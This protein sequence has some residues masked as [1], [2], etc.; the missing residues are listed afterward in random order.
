MSAIKFINKYRRII[1]KNLFVKTLNNPIKNGFISDTKQIKKILIVRPNHRLGNQL[2][3]TPLLQEVIKQFPESKIDLFL[4]GNAGQIIFKNYSEVNKIIALPKKHFKEIFKYLGC[5]LYLKRQKYDL[6]INPMTNSSSGTIA[7]NITNS[8]FKFSGIIGNSET[9]VKQD[10]Y[11]HIAKKPVYNFWEELKTVGIN[12]EKY[13]IPKIDI[14]LN[15]KELTEGKEKLSEIVNTTKEIICIFTFA[16]NE[17]CYSK[18][19]WTEFYGK[20]KTEFKNYTIIEILPVE[21]V[22]QIDFIAPSFYS[23]DIR[24]IASVIANTKLFIGADSGMMHL[25]C[26]TDTTTVGLFSVTNLNTYQPYSN[27]N[28]GISTKNTS[29]D[30]IIEKIKAAI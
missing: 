14:K 20:L 22:S 7:T 29:T 18:E 26:A 13:E 1:T 24:E 27:N 12:L 21:N 9:I 17:K 19:W 28:F 25:S 23:K 4:K 11:S 5:W 3:I 30:E 16:T 2:L 6:V 15:S 8:K 10:D